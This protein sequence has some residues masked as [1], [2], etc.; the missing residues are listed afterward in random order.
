MRVYVTDAFGAS[1]YTSQI[2]VTAGRPLATETSWKTGTEQTLTY[3][4]DASAPGWGNLNAI[5]LVCNST[6]DWNLGLIDGIQS[7][8]IVATSLQTPAKELTRT[9]RRARY[10]TDQGTFRAFTFDGNFAQTTGY[11]G[12][13]AGWHTS[14]GSGDVTLNFGVADEVFFFINGANRYANVN[15]GTIDNWNAGANTNFTMTLKATPRSYTTTTTQ[16]QV[17][18]TYA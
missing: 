7:A 10:R 15:N 3:A 12:T 4:V 2:Q 13:N 1:G 9:D 18:S 6:Q 17:N 14:D 8:K 5:S 11:F 16:T